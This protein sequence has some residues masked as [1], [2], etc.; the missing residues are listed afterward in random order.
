MRKTPFDLCEPRGA[1]GEPPEAHKLYF[2]AVPGVPWDRQEQG[3]EAPKGV[4]TAI[5]VLS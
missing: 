4:Q 1:S 3:I 5:G 2:G